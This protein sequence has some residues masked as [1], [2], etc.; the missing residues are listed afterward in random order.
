MIKLFL[1][2]L[3][4]VTVTVT[5]AVAVTEV[6]C[7]QNGKFDSTDRESSV[8]LIQQTTKR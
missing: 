1:T 3:F 7:Q 8:A 4:T 5:V 2:V 6:T